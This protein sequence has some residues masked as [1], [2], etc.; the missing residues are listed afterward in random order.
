KLFGFARFP[1]KRATGTVVFERQTA[2]DSVINIPINTQ[3]TT[4]G[5]APVV[6]QTTTPA[7]LMPGDTSIQVPAQA[8]LGGAQGN[9]PANAL[10]R[11][12]TPIEGI[13]SFT[14]IA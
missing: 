12:L 6:V 2:A 11:R 5:A 14:N 4:E 8:V 3:L 13:N 10:R 1:A 7:L 9:I